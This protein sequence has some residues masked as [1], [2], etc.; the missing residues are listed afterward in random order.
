MAVKHTW[1]PRRDREDAG[2]DQER[3]TLTL[4]VL[5]RTNYFGCREILTASCLHP[6][7][8]NN[9]QIKL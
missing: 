8:D 1:P 2:R 6:L 3:R 4:A 9:V 7:D 5:V